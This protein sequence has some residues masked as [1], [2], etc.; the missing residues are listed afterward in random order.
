MAFEKNPGFGAL[1]RNEHRT[2]DSHPNATGYIL[3]HRDIRA[4]EEVRPAAWTKEGAKGKFQ[5]MKMS[6][7]REDG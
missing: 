2:T 5:S 7:V 4:G 1:F 6:D 3:A